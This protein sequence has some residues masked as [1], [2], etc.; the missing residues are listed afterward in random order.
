MKKILLLSIFLTCNL[1]AQ[2][3]LH[4]GQPLEKL[5]KLEMGI[6][7][8]VI[9][10]EING[11]INSVTLKIR[12]TKKVEVDGVEYL[13][14]RHDWSSGN[15]DMNGW[16]EY[17]ADA[18]TLAPIQH[19][20]K[21]KSNGKEAFSFSQ[22]LISGL[23][24]TSDNSKKDFELALKTPT[25]NWEID[26]ETYALLN[27]KEGY[28]AVMNFYHPGGQPPAYYHLKVTGSEVIQLPDGREMDCWIIFTDYGGTQPTRFWYTKEGQNFIKMKGQYKQLTIRK[29]RVF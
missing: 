17:Y 22:D 1:Y 21:T 5:K 29:E 26:L 27:M 23:D 14:F 19:I 11:K 8:D 28:H 6:V 18:K 3:T 10:T 16:F 13:R 7:K 4:V 25:Y 12:E 24:T 15:P 20:R 2:D 9:Y